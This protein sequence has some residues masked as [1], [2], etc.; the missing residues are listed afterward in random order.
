MSAISR[1]EPR[2]VGQSSARPPTSH[3]ALAVNLADPDRTGLHKSWNCFRSTWLARDAPASVCV[4]DVSEHAA[5]PVLKQLDV[6]LD[7]RQLA[8]VPVTDPYRGQ[9][10]DPYL[11]QDAPEDVALF[12]A[13]NGGR[14]VARPATVMPG[15]L[16][17]RKAPG[18]VIGLGIA[19]I[20]LGIAVGI[21]G[22]LVIALVNLIHEFGGGDRSF[23][24][25]S[26]ASYLLL[27]FLDFGVAALLIGGAIGLLTGRISGRIACTAGNWA[28]IGFSLFWWGQTTVPV[29]VPAA[30]LVAAAGCLVPLYL[31]RTSSWLGVVPPPQPE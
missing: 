15:L 12:G 7:A 26:D 5:P 2:G 8:H 4:V 11:G 9:L 27:G 3:S 14:S 25:G 20:V 23:Y 19:E 22:L 1:I 24:A 18:F 31:S 10:A 6:R 16:T 13:A 30:L 29:G 17:R 21:L 28:V